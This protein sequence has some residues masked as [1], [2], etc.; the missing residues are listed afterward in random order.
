[1]ERIKNVQPLVLKALAEKPETRKDDFLLVLE[2]F[3]NFIK[4]DMR[5]ETVLLNHKDLGVPSFASILRIR[6]K[7]QRKHPELADP[8]TVEMR[9]SAEREYKAYA[10]NNIIEN[11]L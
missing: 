1:M 6:R 5:L 10:T 2:V 4:G 3:K 8:N 11:Y 9:E 7:L